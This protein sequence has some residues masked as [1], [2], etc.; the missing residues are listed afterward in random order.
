[1][2]R[3]DPCIPIPF[4]PIRVSNVSIVKTFGPN[5]GP[6]LANTARYAPI[7]DVLDVVRNHCKTGLFDTCR[8][9]T[10]GLS[11]YDG[12]AWLQAS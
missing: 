10:V 5:F 7:R 4:S 1:M 2:R 8:H 3:G 6:K 12:I 9:E 11:A